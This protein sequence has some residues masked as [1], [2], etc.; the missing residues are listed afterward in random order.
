MMPGYLPLW[1]LLFAFEYFQEFLGKPSKKRSLYSQADREG[2][3]GVSPFGR[4]SFS[5][6]LAYF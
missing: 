5:E 3:E 6:K 2:A 4:R 1:N